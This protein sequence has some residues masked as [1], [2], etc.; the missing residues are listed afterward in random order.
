MHI[1]L[2]GVPRP[3]Y[4]TKTELEDWLREIPAR[5]GMTRIEGDGGPW[6]YEVPTGFTGLVILAESHVK[7]EYL[8]LRTE[9]ILEPNAG[10]LVL[11]APL[12]Y[13]EAFTC[14]AMDTGLVERIFSAGLRYQV[15]NR[16]MI[17]RGLEYLAGE[18]S[19]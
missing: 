1:T 19:G 7:V 5:I 17:E 13:A 12:V 10:T 16:Q 2:D 14:K 9:T 3:P 6:V 4:L 11:P 15:V 8:H 18:G